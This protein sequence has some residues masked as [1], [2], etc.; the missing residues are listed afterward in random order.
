MHPQEILGGIGKT[1]SSEERI[2]AVLFNPAPENTAPSLGGV[3][4]VDLTASD[5]ISPEHLG[6]PIKDEVWI[7]YLSI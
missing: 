1:H 2:E 6:L 7:S 4:E 3:P 5:P